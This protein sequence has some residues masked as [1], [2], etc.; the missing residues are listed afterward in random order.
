MSRA[1]TGV[2]DDRTVLGDYWRQVVRRVLLTGNRSAIALAF[3]ATFAAFFTVLVGLDITPLSDAQALFYAYSGLVAGNVTLITV[4]VSINQLLLSRELKTPDEVESQIESV[5][6]YRTDVEDA[7]DDIAPVKPLG[8]LRLLVEATR[9]EAQRLG[10][11][12]KYGVVQSGHEQID[13]VVTQLTEQMDQIDELLDE[14]DAGTFSVLSLMLETNYA[15]QI[16]ELRTIRA[17]HGSDFTDD[18]NEEVDALIDRLQEIDIARQYFKS[19]YMQQELAALS[20]TLLYTGLPAVGIALGTLLVMTV[21]TSQPTAVTHLRILLPLTLTVGLLPL[22]VLC[23][24]FL[25]T[26]TVTK[27]TAATLPFTTP[28]QEQ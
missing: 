16:H 5:I 22:C 1:Q 25:R 19:I 24:F 14:S 8:F 4:I 26:A 12:A 17:K 18:M 21:P 7:T 2:G 3:A 23:S 10:G 20:R 11:Y 15:E 9:E 28:E 13:S 6:E 27:L